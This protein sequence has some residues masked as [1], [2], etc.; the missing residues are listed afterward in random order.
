MRPP[1]TRPLPRLQARALGRAPR[2][3][4][5]SP[6][7]PGRGANVLAPEWA[8]CGAPSPA[9]PSN[10]R[11][12]ARPPSAAP[13]APSTRPHRAP[14]LART[15]AHTTPPRQPPPPRTTAPAVDHLM[16]HSVTVTARHQ[17]HPG[18]T[19]ASA[20]MGFLVQSVLGH[21]CKP[22]TCCYFYRYIVLVDETAGR[23]HRGLSPPRTHA[24]VHAV[25]PSHPAVAPWAVVPAASTG[26]DRQLRLVIA[27]QDHGGS[28]RVQIAAGNTLRPPHRI[29]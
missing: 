8:P 27:D 7:C 28:G 11:R 15:R 17:R 1:T 24:Y 26:H 10:S 4:R 16:T 18:Q 9:S 6:R 3:P 12:S 22:P 2:W 21:T 20:S 14:A 13:G 19:R 29:G 23:G 5:A 25:M